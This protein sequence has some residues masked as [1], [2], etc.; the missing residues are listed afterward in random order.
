MPTPQVLLIAVCAAGLWY[1]GSKVVH[2]MKKVAH[3]VEHVIKRND[4]PKS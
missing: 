4:K 2:A 3:K 1:G